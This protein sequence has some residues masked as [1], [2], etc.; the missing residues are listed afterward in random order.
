MDW[1]KP[2]HRARRLK[3]TDSPESGS[4]TEKKPA[5]QWLEQLCEENV[6]LL[7]SSLPIPG[8]QA[9]RKDR[10]RSVDRYLKAM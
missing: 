8:S 2:K 7:Q 1:V 3:S 5:S 9:K 6:A 4:G 10:D